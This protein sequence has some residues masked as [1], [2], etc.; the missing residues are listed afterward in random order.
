MYDVLQGIAR[1]VQNIMKILNGLDWHKY[2]ILGND[3]AHTALS[4]Q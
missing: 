1:T 2:S 4:P 3:I